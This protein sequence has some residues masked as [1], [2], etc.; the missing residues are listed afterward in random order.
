[1]GTPYA[2]QTVSGYSSSP[3]PD[4]GSVSAANKVTYAKI[5]GQIG[6]PLNSFATAINSALRTALNVTPTGQGAAYT[7]TTADHLRQIEVTGTTT[8]SLGDAATMV[9]ASMGYEVPIINAGSGT[10][11]VALITAAN[12]L[13]GKA[14]GTVSLAPRQGAVFSVNSTSNGY[15]VKSIANGVIFDATDPS[16]QVRLDVSGITTGTVRTLTVQ[17]ASDTLVGRATTD[18]LTNKTLTSPVLN[19]GVSGTAVAAQ[20]DQASAS[21]TSLI[22]TPGRQ[23]F[24]PSAAKVWAAYS[25]TTLSGSYNVSSITSNG[26]G[27]KNTNFTTAFA[28]TSY[29]IQAS[30]VQTFSGVGTPTYCDVVSRSTSSCRV[31]TGVRDAGTQSGSDDLTFVTCYGAQ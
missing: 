10:V 29:C 14:N 13:A 6:D 31:A 16:K 19:T 1:M 21:S 22:V 30:A 23:Q 3:P 25:G 18:T 28:S 20:A 15:N 7:T 5:K 27:D 12:T 11:T 9:A 17:D 26:A 8:I 2:N 4:D 24:H